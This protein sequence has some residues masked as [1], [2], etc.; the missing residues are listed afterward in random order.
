MPTWATHKLRPQT[1]RVESKKKQRYLSQVGALGRP[2][3]RGAQAEDDGARDERAE[4]RVELGADVGAVAQLAA[5]DGPLAAEFGDE[6][7]RHEHARHHDGGVQ[8]RQRRHAQAVLF[9]DGTL[10]ESIGFISFFA[11]FGVYSEN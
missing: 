8:H 2:H 4:R 3:G 9:V 1:P 7:R 10:H 11:G 5:H 6:P